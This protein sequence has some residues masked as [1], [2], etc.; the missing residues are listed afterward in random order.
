MY[1]TEYPPIAL[2]GDF[3]VLRNDYNRVDAQGFYTKQVLLIQ[4]KGEPFQFMWALPGGF[5]NPDELIEAAAW[6]ELK[7]ETGVTNSG[8]W[9]V[10]VF[11]DVLRD[12]R[13]RVVS[14]VYGT[15][16]IDDVDLFASDDAMDIGWF[17]VDD[18][19]ELA[20]D[21]ELMIKKALDRFAD[22]DD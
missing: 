1:T 9:F 15:V 19:P 21:H 4:R 7:E 8:C 14:F 20:F 6:R 13:Q 18:L 10:G 11:D 3:V 5:V 2:T 22:S 12:P 16:L 17:D